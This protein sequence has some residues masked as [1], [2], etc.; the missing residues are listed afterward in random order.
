MQPIENRLLA[1]LPRTERTRLL[2]LS[3]W[4]SLELSE[5]LSKPGVAPPFVYFP[6]DG[7]ISVVTLMDGRPVLE[8]GMVG[9]EGML[10][11]QLALGRIPMESL[12]P[13]VQGD[14][15]AWRMRATTFERELMRSAALK[16]VVH[17]YLQVTI[18]QLATSAACLR[19]HMI[20]PRLARWLLMTQDRAHSKTFAVTHEFLAFM[21]GVRRVGITTAAATLQRR[22]LI[23]YRR[24]IV[25]IANR[26][27]L[28]SSACS[29]YAADRKVYGR[30]FS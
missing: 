2:K 26:R 25:T 27:G 22:G 4:V 14:G 30:L 1:R 10:G 12:H 3:E 8:V 19:F 29:C 6:T 21:L 11:A 16:R 7:F 23:K 18:S 20:G 9:T 24:G 28:L 15:H 17:S 5:A 13:I